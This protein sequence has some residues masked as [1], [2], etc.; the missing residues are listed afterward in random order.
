MGGDNGPIETP[1]P[2]LRR[3]KSK[4]P[5]SESLLSSECATDTQETDLGFDSE[6]ARIYHDLGLMTPKEQKESLKKLVDDINSGRVQPPPPPIGKETWVD[7]TVALPSD[8]HGSKSSA[9]GICRKL[10]WEDNHGRK[11]AFKDES[12]PADESK[13]ISFPGLWTDAEWDEWEM[14]Q[15]RLWEEEE[16]LR[17]QREKEES[18]RLQK[19]KEKREEARRLRKEKEEALRLQEE[20]EKHEETRRLQKD[21]RKN[22]STAAGSMLAIGNGPVPDLESLSPEDRISWKSAPLLPSVAERED[23]QRKLTDLPCIRFVKFLDTLSVEERARARMQKTPCSG[24]AQPKQAIQL[25]LTDLS[26]VRFVKFIDTLSAEEAK[27]M[28]VE[29]LEAGGQDTSKCKKKKKKEEQ[30][31][32]SEG[33]FRF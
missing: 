27:E 19:E 22:K 12:Q 30:L 31:E 7:P 13:H 6:V 21:A 23:R 29:N 5:A 3:C 16:A 11:S 28:I 20:K 33:T 15:T 1:P 32:N 26:C 2:R 25:K 14:E 4:T 8:V 9:S 17:L 18:L 24:Q 10:T